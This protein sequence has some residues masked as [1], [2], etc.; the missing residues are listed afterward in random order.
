MNIERDVCIYV[1][2]CGGG[3]VLIKSDKGVNMLCRA[4]MG[5]ENGLTYMVRFSGSHGIPERV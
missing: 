5:S 1:C 4:N 3:G 2:V